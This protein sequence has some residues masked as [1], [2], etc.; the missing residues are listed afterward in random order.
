[1]VPTYRIKTT[2]PDNTRLIEAWAVPSEIGFLNCLIEEYEGLAVMRTVNR[3]E[4]H[5]KFW[6]PQG[7]MDLFIQVLEDFIAR[8]WV[9]RYETIEPWWDIQDPENP[10]LDQGGK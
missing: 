1:M 6:V 10:I 5:L 8:G 7:Q 9:F 2:A 4:G 3:R